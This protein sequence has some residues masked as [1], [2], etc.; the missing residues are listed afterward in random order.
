MRSLPPD[1]ARPRSRAVAIA[2]PATRPFRAAKL[3]CYVLLVLLLVAA[4]FAVAPA[5]EAGSR[6]FRFTLFPGSD[7]EFT[8]PYADVPVRIDVAMSVDGPEGATSMLMS[9]LV[10]QSGRS[11]EMSWIASDSDARPTFGNTTWGGREIA[12]IWGPD[13]RKPYAVMSIGQRRLGGIKI[14]QR[15]VNRSTGHYFVTLTY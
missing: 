13:G 11:L 12:R 9:A 1:A 8:I 10:T 5:A 2:V 3:F 15:N 7:Y 4:S 6:T 14:T